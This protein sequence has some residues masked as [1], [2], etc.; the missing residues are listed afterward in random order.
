LYERRDGLL[1]QDNQNSQLTFPRDLRNG[2]MTSPCCTALGR[3]RS[4]SR[5]AGR[6]SSPTSRTS[7]EARRATARRWSLT[8]RWRIRAPGSRSPAGCPWQGLT[9]TLAT[10]QLKLEPVRFRMNRFHFYFQFQRAPLHRGG[11][12]AGQPRSLRG[13][14]LTFVHFSAQPKPFLTQK[15]IPK[16]PQ[17]PRTP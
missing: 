13:Q 9:R 15:Q 5:A 10:F 14:G 1:T 11:D 8:R 3:S 7:L 2:R 16:R 12:R 4:S 17:I 6:P